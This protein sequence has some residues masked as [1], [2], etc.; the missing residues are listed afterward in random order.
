MAWSLSG[1]AG[2]H[3]G[4]AKPSYLKNVHKLFIPVFRN[5]TLYPDLEG[6]VTAIVAEQFQQDGTY[7]LTSRENCDAILSCT[8][9]KVSRAPERSVEGNVLLT[10]EFQV[11]LG[12]RYQ[13]IEA[14][15]D[16]ILDSGRTD[17]STDYFV[18]QDVTQ[19]ER[20]AIPLAAAQMAERLVS[21]IS[22]GF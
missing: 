19:D 5:N 21:I 22:E 15:T 12:V 1:C 13:L 9:E 18:G 6:M 20:Q 11:D 7:E 17:G 3:L 2:Y 14:G 8:L 16:K 4:E 10:S